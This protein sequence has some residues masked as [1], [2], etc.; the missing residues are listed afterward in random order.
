M[1]RS[2]S[3]RTAADQA[4]A[5]P[6][7][8]RCAGTPSTG[9]RRKH[10]AAVAL[11]LS[12]KLS[13]SGIHGQLIFYKWHIRNTQVA[14]SHV[15]VVYHLSDHTDWIVDNEIAHPK[16]VPTD[17]SPIQLVFLLSNAPS[18]PVDVELQDGLNR[19]SYF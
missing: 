7:L 9:D 10:H 8:H 11:A 15:F 5:R 12:S 13:A 16:L 3:G 18:A 1:D 14:G 4:G 6:Y 17:T 19:L 2:I